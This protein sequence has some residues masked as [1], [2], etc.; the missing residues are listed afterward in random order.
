M[1]SI[2]VDPEKNSIEIEF[3]PQIQERFPEL[4]KGYTDFR[5]DQILSSTYNK[6]SYGVYSVEQ[7]KSIN[8][9]SVKKIEA[10][11]EI[12]NQHVS[13]EKIQKI[14][15]KL[16]RVVEEQ[17]NQSSQNWQHA[18]VFTELNNIKVD[19]RA[20]SNG[21]PAEI[22]KK[23]DLDI[24]KWEY[25]S[26]QCHQHQSC[27][28]FYSYV[29]QETIK[30]SEI[31]LNARKA[32][33]NRDALE[34]MV[35]N[36][37]L[38][39]YE[40]F[41]GLTDA[42]DVEDF[43]KQLPE[44]QKRLLNN[45]LGSFSDHSKEEFKKLIAELSHQFPDPSDENRQKLEDFLAM[46]RNV[47][48]YY[49]APTSDVYEKSL[50]SMYYDLKTIS[51]PY[52]NLKNL[53]TDTIFRPDDYYSPEQ[54]GISHINV[55]A[56]SCNH[57]H[58]GKRIYAHEVGHA[59]SDWINTNRL[60][61]NSKKSYLELRSCIKESYLIQS[62]PFYSFNHPGDSAY[63]EEDMADVISFLT[64]PDPNESLFTCI[65]LEPH[66]NGVDYANLSLS[67]GHEG[68]H[69]E[70]IVRV[71]NEALYKGAPIGTSCQKLLDQNKETIKLRKC[72]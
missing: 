24:F 53:C 47:S 16:T 33:E 48:Q 58:H 41:I 12:L 72:R 67:P 20:E 14:K 2:V 50:L 34:K 57:F 60:S 28:E 65:L 19:V 32:F 15:D 23:F 43:R 69:S 5:K 25:G 30:P 40:D 45:A 39:W 59:L 11:L 29:M 31:L 62:S 38:N 56:Y 63:V 18:N 9:E 49:N 44:I 51:E 55:S 27:S 46:F 54:F 68:P 3:E 21:L 42:Q 66:K 8:E 71:I 1:S 36:C 37:R 35:N 4:L 17:L 61:E 64:Y 26:F 13:K 6:I 52:E 70:S 22:Q 10:S 7:A